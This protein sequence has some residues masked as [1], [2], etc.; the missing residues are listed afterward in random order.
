MR[1][2]F[3]GNQKIGCE[4]LKYLIDRKEDVIAVFAIDEDY[5]GKISGTSKGTEWFSSV[6]KMAEENG[7]ITQYP[8]DV[9][10]PETVQFIRGLKPDI[11]FSVS[12]DQMI[13][14]E[15]LNIPTCGCINMHGSLLPK[16]RGHA[17]INWAIINGEKETG[18]TMHYMVKRSDAGDIIGQRK[19]PIYFEDRAVDV[20][21]KMVDAGVELFKDMFPLI[22]KGITPRTKQD[23]SKGNYCRRRR[24]DDGL[25]DWSKSAVEI[26][27]WVR[28]L[29][30][31]Y[32]GAFTYFNEKKIYIWKVSIDN[33]VLEK[34]VPGKILKLV[35]GKGVK[36][37]TG[38][39]CIVVKDIQEEN[40]AEEIDACK[41]FENQV[42]E[43]VF[44][45]NNT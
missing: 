34:A 33:E 29:T 3:A 12:W 17:P 19:V 37:A 21:D 30:K 43:K 4:C 45:S 36:V 16:N 31:P 35:E 1:I 13:G 38:A 22:K 25:I 6:G 15:I 10:S 2:I 9:N 28:A 40:A 7:I 14:E 42:L 8:E 24:P 27:N 11:L 39:G 26:Y 5:W 44:H 18:I 23:I 20:Y 32:P 41:Y